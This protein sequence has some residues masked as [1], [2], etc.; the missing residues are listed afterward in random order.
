MREQHERLVTVLDEAAVARAS[1]SGQAEIEAWPA[2]S[3]VWGHYAE[4]TAAGPA[5]CRTENVSACHRGR[6]R[7]R[8]RRAARRRVEARSASRSSRSRTRSTTSS[9][10]VPVF[11][12]TRTASAYP[13]VTSVMSILV[14]IDACSTESGLPLA[15]GRRRRGSADRRSRRRARRHRARRSAGPQSSWQPGEAV[16]STGWCRTTATPTAPRGPRRVLVASYAPERE[17]LHAHAVL[18]RAQRRDDDVVGGRRA[19]PHQHA[20]RLRRRR[21]RARCRGGRAL[22]DTR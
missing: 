9:P 13:G 16:C 3:H 20:R 15:R 17:Q 4:A 12:R 11:G 14:A 10:A 19:V 5:I 22:H 18:R 7:A 1:E 8:R 2:G 21:S 6:R